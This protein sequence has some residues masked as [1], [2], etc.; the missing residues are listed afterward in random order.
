MTLKVLYSQNKQFLLC[1]VQEKN[2][3]QIFSFFLMLFSLCTVGFLYFFS[4]FSCTN[5]KD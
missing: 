4:K 2:Y 3:D 5:T 1:R